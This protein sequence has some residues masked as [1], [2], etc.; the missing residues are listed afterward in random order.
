MPALFLT[1]RQYKT[2]TRLRAARRAGLLR[3]LRRARRRDAPNHASSSGL[4]ATKFVARGEKVRIRAVISKRRRRHG[5]FAASQSRA[6]SSG[7]RSGGDACRGLRWRFVARRGGPRRRSRCASSAA[8]AGH[9]TDRGAADAGRPRAEDRFSDDSFAVGDRRRDHFDSGHRDDFR[10]GHRDEFSS[11]H[12]DDF[13]SGHRDDADSDEVAG[14]R[15][16]DR[17]VEEP[18]ERTK[19]APLPRE[20]HRQ[21]VAE[22]LFVEHPEGRAGGGDGC[23]ARVGNP[24]A[25]LFRVG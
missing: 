23:G 19:V 6:R 9:D 11:D 15:D 20:A 8:D 12:R 10:S 22:I 1:A 14:G 7:R 5:A 21:R 3:E 25:K 13:C 17:A 2:R 16:S 4:E 24:D 18:G